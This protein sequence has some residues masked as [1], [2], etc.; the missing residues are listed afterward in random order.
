[1]VRSMTGYGQAVR[2]VSGY[3]LQID[4]KSV[5]HRYGEIVVRMP[6]EWMMFEDML[7]KQAQQIVKRGRVD[8]FVNVEREPSSEQLVTVNWPLLERYNKAAE[9]IRERLNLPDIDRLK[10]RDLLQ[11]PD[12][13]MEADDQMTDIDQFREQLQ[14]CM[15]DA[16]EQLS[17]MREAEGRNLQEDIR[18]RIH[19]IAR[20]RQLIEQAAPQAV[21]HIRLRLR[22]RIQ[23][24][25]SD[26]STFDEQRFVMEVALLAERANVDEELTRL[27]SHGD[28]FHALLDLDEPVGKKLDFLTQEMNR[29]VNT[30]GSK[31]NYAP[32]IRLVIE[33][34]SE[35]EKIREQVQNI[36]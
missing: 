28:Q 22:Q 23:E 3:I 32:I 36:E 21:E 15:T 20:L 10:P 11:I 25:L 35:I 29:E 19:T 31:G 27:A 26:A 7:R 13:I 34:K 12:I 6:R 5:N 18:N 17:A 2:K 16:M 8:I 4:V 24:L 1:M 9:Q 33:L 14:R 30:I